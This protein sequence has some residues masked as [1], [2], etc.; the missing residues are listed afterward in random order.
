MK[1]LKFILKVFG[2]IGTVSA[3]LFLATSYFGFAQSSNGKGSW[4]KADFHIHTT[5]SDGDI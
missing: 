2:S 1:N 4:I 3:L 5:M